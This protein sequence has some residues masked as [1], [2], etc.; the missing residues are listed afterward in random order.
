MD[1]DLV[2]IR[3]QRY[4]KEAGQKRAQEEAQQREIEMIKQEEAKKKAEQEKIVNNI[5]TCVA[6]LANSVDIEDI[7]ETLG[8][9]ASYIIDNLP[10]LGEGY[11]DRL[12]ALLYAIINAISTN[13]NNKYI[14]GNKEQMN[15]SL[16]IANNIKMLMETLGLDQDS[17]DIDM[18]M[19]TS[20]DERMARELSDQLNVRGPR[21]A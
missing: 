4:E 10:K 14:A 3:R 6:L 12:I 15:A 20:E 18:S 9:I 19:D 5:E 17:V 1:Q 7:A 2:A 11:V 8:D 16:S 13:P 21:R